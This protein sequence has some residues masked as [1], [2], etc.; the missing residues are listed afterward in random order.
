EVYNILYKEEENK[1]DN[2]SE[3][4]DDN[5]AKTVAKKDGNLKA[6]IYNPS[7]MD[8][9]EVQNNKTDQGEMEKLDGIM[10][11]ALSI[12][13]KSSNQYGAMS[14]EI[15]TLIKPEINLED[16]LKEY[17]ISSL[18]EK[19]STYE[20][21]NRKFIHQGIY[22]PGYKK[23]DEL[24][25]VYIALDSSSSVSLD[26]YKTFLGVVKDVCDGFYEYKVTILPFDKFV[27]KEHIVSFDS[28]NQI[29]EEK[30]YIPKSDGGTNFDAVLR[31][32]KTTDIRGDN[33]LMVLT[34]GEFEI[35]E[36]LVSQTLFLISSKKNMK[37]FESYGRVIQFKI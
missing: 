2:G 18:F 36:S 31:Y 34:D 27:K 29:E 32:L 35:N 1:E 6:N 13:Q 11:Q 21:V 23:S 7:K 16:I 25:E 26:E 30:F 8:I 15:D 14:I 3:K 22:L 4:K 19:Q 20:R 10:I 9:D 17:L 37:K 12:A 28:F 24:I 33:L 5:Q